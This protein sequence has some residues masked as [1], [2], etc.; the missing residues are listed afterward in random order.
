VPA[1]ALPRLSGRRAAAALGAVAV[2]VLG[3]LTV[4]VGAGAQQDEAVPARAA[5]PAAPAPAPSP[6]A[7]FEAPVPSPPPPPPP[8]AD[9]TIRSA[10]QP[11]L[12]I[13]TALGPPPGPQVDP[14]PAAVA[15][16]AQRFAFVVGVTDY[17]APTVDTIGSA[18]DAL[19]IGEQL[20]AAGWL[21]DNVRVLTDG[22]VTGA[23]IRDGMAWLAERSEPG[24]FSLFHY[25]GHVKQKG[26][27]REALWPV[28]RA[29]VDDTEVTAAL[30]A[31]R[32]RLWVDIA[33]CEAA[34]F[35]D[36]LPSERVLFTGSSKA[37][38]KSYEFPAWGKSIWTGLLF[39]L[40]LGQGKADADGDGRTTAGEAVRYAQY[41][42]QA[43]SI[44]Q[45]PYG[46]QTPQ[47][48]GAP[49]LGWTLAD[50]PA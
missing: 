31:T 37:T 24:T 14:R 10:A 32:G 2:L 19:F 20:V 34:S 36:G 1:S 11:D 48:A 26:G 12:D 28:D 13:T 33:G 49:D 38:E 29:F 23:A 8:V 46:Q 35:L 50:P 22:Q 3:V 18:N 21:P 44:G 42:S 27:G 43:I 7:S 9:P 25:S 40:G 5:T 15:P 47:F 4:V 41:Y 6:P 16:P 39:D 45:E 30:A 17:R